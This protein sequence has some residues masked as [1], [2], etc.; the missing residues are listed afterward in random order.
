VKNNAAPMSGTGIF[1]NK[2]KSEKTPNRI[3]GTKIRKFVG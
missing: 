1:L 2:T 3:S